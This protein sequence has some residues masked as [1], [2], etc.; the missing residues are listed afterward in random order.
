MII[1]FGNFLGDFLSQSHPLT[2]IIEI[3]FSV[4]HS[5]IFIRHDAIT[6]KGGGRF[7]KIIQH[8]YSL[9]LSLC[10]QEIFF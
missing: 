3:F 7:E 2:I 6:N 4:N 10:F 8:E 9:L 1:L 5:L